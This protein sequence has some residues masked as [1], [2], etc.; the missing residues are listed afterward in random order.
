MRS[1]APALLPIFRSQHQA[2]LLTALYLHRSRDYA[3]TELAEQAGVPVSTAH[4]EVARLAKAGLID[5]RTV[6]R[7]R[8]YRADLTHPAAHALTE[9]LLVSF[10]PA[11]VVAEEFGPLSDV[12]EVLIFGS[13]AARYAGIDGPPPADVDVL[14]V[15]SVRRAEVYAAADRAAARL[16]MPVNPVLRSPE[17]WQ[18][19]GTDHLDAL[20]EQIDQSPV[21]SVL[22]TGQNGRT[23]ASFAIDAADMSAGEMGEARA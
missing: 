18:A 6:G 14:V 9:L 21:L 11:T 15:G 8:L 22:S 3:L 10:G 19:R 16:S 23:P 7:T 2:E 17:Q 4:R 12:Q 1:D 13:W 5:V 20:L